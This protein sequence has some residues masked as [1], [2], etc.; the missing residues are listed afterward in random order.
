M[1]LPRSGRGAAGSA[2]PCPRTGAVHLSSGTVHQPLEA[3][4]RDRAALEARGHFS[5]R[6]P[7]NLPP[8]VLTLMMRPV[9]ALRLAARP[10]RAFTNWE[11][12][13]TEP[14][15]PGPFGGLVAIEFLPRAPN[16][17]HSPGHPFP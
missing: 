5:A 2:S 4:L 3:D 15:R 17:S 1:A 8:D 13:F 9:P 11:R 14:L 10:V 16:Q 12:C 7:L 6:T